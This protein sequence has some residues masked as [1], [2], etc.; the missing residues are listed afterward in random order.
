MSIIDKKNI[1]LAF[2]N[3]EFNNSLIELKDHFNFNL[4]VIDNLKDIKNLKNYNGLIIHEDALSEN[5]IKEILKNKNVNKIIFYSSKK[6]NGLENIERLSLPTSV[7]QINKIIINNI[8]KKEFK[9]NSSLKI[10]NYKLDKNLRRLFKDELSLELTEKEIELIEL[11]YKKT[12]VKKKEILSNIWKY[13]EDADTHTVETHIYRLRKKI[14]D[15]FKD[16]M[17]IKNEK[18]G[19][20]I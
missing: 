16:E 4:Q 1:I 13:S 6:L 14:K 9:D 20:T 7:D 17:F 18:K 12:F 15:V 3:K 10:N 11:L 8:V 19:Y 5:G 2:G